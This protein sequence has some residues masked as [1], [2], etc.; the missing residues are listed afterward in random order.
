MLPATP[1]VLKGATVLTARAGSRDPSSIPSVSR[2]SATLRHN[3]GTEG[4]DSDLARVLESLEF[5][6]KPCGSEASILED[7]SK[8]I[9]LA[10]T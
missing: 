1:Q 10:H 3:S 6:L 5:C 7:L 4:M 9:D 8:A 2:I